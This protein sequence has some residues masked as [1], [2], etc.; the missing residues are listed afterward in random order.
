MKA[1]TKLVAL[2]VLGFHVLADSF[3]VQPDEKK[4]SGTVNSFI[5]E[6]A[7][8]EEG[9][10]PAKVSSFTCDMVDGK[11]DEESV[12]AYLQDNIAKVVGGLGVTADA[13]AEVA[14][15]PATEATAPV[16]ETAPAAEKSEN[17]SAENQSSEE[18]AAQ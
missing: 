10:S 17:T 9:A 8:K 3:T 16:A 15:V 6:A 4:I 12:D 13:V 7:S 5:D 11:T 1:I 18:Q 14:A 2:S